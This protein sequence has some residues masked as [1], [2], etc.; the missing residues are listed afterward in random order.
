L[1]ACRAKRGS[2]PKRHLL[3]ISRSRAAQQAPTTREQEG[4]SASHGQMHKPF[5]MEVVVARRSAKRVTLVACWCAPIT[6]RRLFS[7]RAFERRARPCSPTRTV[8][9]LL[10]G[11]NHSMEVKCRLRRIWCQRPNVMANAGA[12]AQ[13]LSFVSDKGPSFVEPLRFSVRDAL[14]Q[15]MEQSIQRWHHILS[16]Y[17]TWCNKA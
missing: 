3:R 9:V 2:A 11:H 5:H 13:G 17:G 15:A 12:Q 4:A 14:L 7:R 10:H 1:T 6:A 16:P 8:S